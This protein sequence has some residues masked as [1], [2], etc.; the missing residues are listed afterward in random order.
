MTLLS[1]QKQI[2]STA[3]FQITWVVQHTSKT[4]TA[5]TALSTSFSHTLR[6]SSLG[7]MFRLLQGHDDSP[8]HSSATKISQPVDF[9]TENNSTGMSIN[10]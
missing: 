8:V 3:Y 6:E 1:T 10:L 7:T 5:V 2:F 4:L 9:Q